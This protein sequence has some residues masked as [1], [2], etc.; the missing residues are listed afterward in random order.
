MMAPRSW[1]YHLQRPHLLKLSSWELG[2]I[3]GDTGLQSTAHSVYLLGAEKGGLDPVFFALA[4]PSGD[5]MVKSV[6]PKLCRTLERQNLWTFTIFHGCCSFKLYSF[7]IV[8]DPWVKKNQRFC[9]VLERN[10]EFPLHD[11]GERARRYQEPA[12]RMPGPDGILEAW[13]RSN[14][15]ATPFVHLPLGLY[16]ICSEIFENHR[17]TSSHLLLTPPPCL[18]TVAGSTLSLIRSL[19]VS[20]SCC[21]ALIAHPE[22]WTR[23]C[24][25]MTV[26]D[27][28]DS[29]SCLN[30]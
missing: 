12:G 21:L 10:A 16:M 17:L 22:R 5:T 6:P 18:W 30:A 13:A 20:L 2:W 19:G 14:P 9:W 15:K 4:G 3:L 28:C 24:A 29:L 26:L 8:S 11:R 1:P 7:S 23:F 25:C 27:Y